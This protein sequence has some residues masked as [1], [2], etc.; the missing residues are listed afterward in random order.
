VQWLGLVA[1]AV[2]CAGVTV[3]ASGSGRRGRDAL[4]HPAAVEPV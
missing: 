3:F 2:A 1:V 4:D